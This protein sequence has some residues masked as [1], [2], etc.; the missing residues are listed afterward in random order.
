M[1]EHRLHTIGRST[2]ATKRMWREDPES[3]QQS[4]DK[5]QD[6][7]NS[8]SFDLNGNK[9]GID[10]DGDNDEEEKPDMRSVLGFLNQNEWIFNLNIGNIM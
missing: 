9:Q 2:P 10:E 1:M 4:E 3:R 6:N 8:N 7:D 5:K